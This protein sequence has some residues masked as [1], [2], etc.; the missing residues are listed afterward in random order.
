[1]NRSLH[2]NDAVFIIS[3][4]SDSSVKLDPELFQP[5]VKKEK[6]D[7]VVQGGVAGPCGTENTAG[8]SGVGDMS[9][10]KVRDVTRT[11]V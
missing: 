1:M 9:V 6:M 4:D 8:P 3:S 2:I 5:P 10:K 7:Y 11:M